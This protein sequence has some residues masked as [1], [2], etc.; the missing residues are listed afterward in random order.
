MRQLMAKLLCCLFI[1]MEYLGVF[2]TATM[3]IYLFSGGAAINSYTLC[4]TVIGSALAT[5]GIFVGVLKI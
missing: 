3:I 2:F 4:G 5:W 1:A